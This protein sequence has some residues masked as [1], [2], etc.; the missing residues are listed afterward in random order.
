MRPL[1]AVEITPI[2]IGKASE[3]MTEYFCQ[4]IFGISFNT[5]GAVEN[6][7]CS[8]AAPTASKG[9]KPKISIVGTISQPQPTLQ[10]PP[11][12]IPTKPII[13]KIR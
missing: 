10:N 6:T 8:S 9:W 11:Q 4:E 7:I 1:K 2:A 3:R 5:V 13:G 12:S